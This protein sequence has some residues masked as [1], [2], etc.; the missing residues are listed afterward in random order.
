MRESEYGTS[1]CLKVPKRKGKEKER[2]EEEDLQFCCRAGGSSES[3]YARFN[4]FEC[5][6][7]INTELDQIRLD[8]SIDRVELAPTT[9]L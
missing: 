2:N 4:C 9:T 6:E 5:A 7:D 8:R 3:D 1:A